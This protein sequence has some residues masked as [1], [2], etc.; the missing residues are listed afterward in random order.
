MS[1]ERMSTW[2]LMRSRLRATAPAG[3]EL[4]DQRLG[5]GAGD[6]PVDG[7]GA[8]VGRDELRLDPALGVIASQAVRAALELDG[9]QLAAADVQAD[10]LRV[11]R[12]A[13]ARPRRT[14]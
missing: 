2:R 6:V 11:M 5:L 14:S 9:A 7:Q 1:I 10:R 13:D 8:G 3:A 12:T 4:L